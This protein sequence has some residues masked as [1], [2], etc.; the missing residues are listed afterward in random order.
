MQ[1]GMLGFV[2]NGIFL[3]HWYHILDKVVGSSMTSKIGVIIKVAADQ[4][5]YAPFAIASFFYFT[6]VRELRD[7]D[8]ANRE[9]KSKLKQSFLT[10]FLADC[11][12][13][14]TSNFVN[15]RYINLAYR[16]SFTAGIQLLWQTYL[17]ITSHGE[18]D[19]L[20][21]KVAL[22]QGSLDNMHT[23]DI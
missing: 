15:F 12:L 6:S 13:W 4:F 17:S 3:Y 8:S 11:T 2:M 23:E 14:P 1:V 7:I 20:D 9:F 22:D 16:P 10:T 5:I 21:D 19:P 18:V